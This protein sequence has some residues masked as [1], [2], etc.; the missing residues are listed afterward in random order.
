[1]FGKIYLALGLLRFSGFTTRMGFLDRMSHDL[2]KCQIG[3][4]DA[5]LPSQW[6][7]GRFLTHYLVASL[8]IFRRTD[9][10]LA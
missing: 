1:M 7:G 6:K 9:I 10:L 4:T 8:F 5:K 2:K 3:I